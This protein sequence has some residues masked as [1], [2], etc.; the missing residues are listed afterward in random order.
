MK[1][2]ICG[3]T[4][5]DDALAAVETGADMLGFNFYA[6]SPRVISAQDCASIVKRLRKRDLESTIVGV[7]VNMPVHQIQRIMADCELHLAQLHGDETPSDLEALAP[8]AFKAIRPRS[9]DEANRQFQAFA[10]RSAPSPALL[11]D[12]YKL[13]SYGGTGEVADWGVAAVLAQSAPLLLAGG[14]T[15]TNVAAAISQVRPWGVDVAS[16][17]EQA[18]GR[19]D[20][21]KMRAFIQAIRRQEMEKNAC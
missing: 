21:L 15:A 3:L 19:K 2:K 13:G 12:A 5:F 1:I 18:P 8:R 7:F 16:G 11:L 20:P 4:T 10:G 9:E 14:L 17:V 6:D